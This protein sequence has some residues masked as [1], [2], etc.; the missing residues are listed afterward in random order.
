MTE[1]HE[2][3]RTIHKELAT[4]NLQ[5]AMLTLDCAPPPINCILCQSVIS[6]N[7]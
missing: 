7:L 1:V 2:R 6:A 5:H 3:S 4:F